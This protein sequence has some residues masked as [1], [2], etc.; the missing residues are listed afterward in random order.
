V[1][2]RDIEDKRARPRAK[3]PRTYVPGRLV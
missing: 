2:I 1:A 3:P